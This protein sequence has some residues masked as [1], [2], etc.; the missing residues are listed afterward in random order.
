MCN[1]SYL[2]KPL[3]DT[4]TTQDRCNMALEHCE[5]ESIFNF[6]RLYFCT[7]QTN[8]LIFYPLGV[9]YSSQK[10]NS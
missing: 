2:M 5:G 8:N 9:S 1:I 4:F 7:L 6:Y 10:V 3:T